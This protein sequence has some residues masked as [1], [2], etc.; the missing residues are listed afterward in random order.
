M[1]SPIPKVYLW[2]PE[3]NKYQLSL[4]NPC[5]VLHHGKCAANKEGCWVW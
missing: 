1:V 3:F 2:E 4:M 5:D